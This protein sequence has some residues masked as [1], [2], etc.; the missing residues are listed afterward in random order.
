VYALP[1]NA[2]FLSR[3][4][5]GRL[6]VRRA[7]TETN[8]Q[9]AR[10]VARTFAPQRAAYAMGEPLTLNTT[11]QNLL[12][13][14][15]GLVVTLTSLSPHLT[16]QQGTF[17]VGSLATLATASNTTAPFRLAVAGSG[18]P[19]NTKAVLRYRFTASGGF[20]HDQYEE[21]VLNPD[22]AVLDAGDL[23][24]TLTTRGNLGYDNLQGTVG[25]GVMYRNGALLLSEGGLLLATSPTRVSDRLRTSGGQARQSFFQA[26]QIRR[27]QPG[28]RADQ[29]A[30]SV[31]QDSVPAAGSQVRSVGV[32]VRQRGYSWAAAGRRDFTVLEYSL[33]NLT[34]DTLRPLYAGLFTDWDVPNPDASGSNAA[35]WDNARALGYT[36]AVTRTGLHA[37]VKLL[38]GGAPTAY[39]A[40][41][42]APAGSAVRLSDGFSPAEKF[43]MLS[44]GTTQTTAGL[45]GG[46]DVVQ[47][48]GTR[49]PFLAPGDSTT[50]AFAVLAAPSLAQLQAA[51][52]AASQAYA[53][54]L[55]AGPAQ[56]TAG[57]SVFP[58]PSAGHVQVE[59]PP[60]FGQ[61]E[62]QLL[63]AQGRLV[64]RHA[65]SG[66]HF[67][68]EL[69]GL[70]EGL[71][72]VR[73]VGSMGVL[74][75]P[76]VVQ[77]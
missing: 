52:D 70:A 68:M 14:V 11:V 35:A 58:N 29:E 13:P 5:T 65:G 57:F 63:D 53:A 74:T 19:L 56:L 62:V 43:L 73:L 49:L 7:L 50:V 3:L 34:A 40:D 32:Q 25:T 55:P 4:G 48:V 72:L 77:Y 51:A 9:E 75:R 37:G 41:A 31:F 28:P 54:L 33:K 44:S 26:D 69:V 60:G 76:V 39:A 8:R 18:V 1:A 6:N 46:A 30:Y 45:P 71:Y 36:Y 15:T 17:A 42:N 24:L 67:N 59:V 61:F 38:R 21:V 23:S 12:Q 16:V 27:L 20:Q 47:V 2:A 10:V 22:Y 64:R 66:R